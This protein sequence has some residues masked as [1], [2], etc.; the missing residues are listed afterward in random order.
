MKLFICIC[1]DCVC[2]EGGKICFVLNAEN[3]GLYVFLHKIVAGTEFIP[4][5]VCTHMMK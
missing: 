1:C 4:D 5:F 2:V 3:V